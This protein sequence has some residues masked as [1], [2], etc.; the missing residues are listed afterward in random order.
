MARP[1]CRG[2]T[3]GLSAGVW[4]VALVPAEA[5]TPPQVPRAFPTALELVEA[6]LALEPVLVSGNESGPNRREVPRARGLPGA[7]ERLAEA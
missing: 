3:R 2:R 1:G 6:S 5:V 4:E 7:K